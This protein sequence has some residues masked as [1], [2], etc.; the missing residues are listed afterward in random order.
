MIPPLLSQMS[1]QSVGDYESI[2][3]SARLCTDDPPPELMY[4]DRDWP[5]NDR[6]MGAIVIYNCPFRTMTE[7]EETVGKSSGQSATRAS[8][9]RR[10]TCIGWYF[11]SNIRNASTTRTLTRWCGGLVRSRNVDV[12]LKKNMSVLNSLTFVI[13]YN[14]LPAGDSGAEGKG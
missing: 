1:F 3:C 8:S 12:S 14:F 9:A 7:V 13:L 5:Y 2:S 6:R 11:Q 10:A 4:M